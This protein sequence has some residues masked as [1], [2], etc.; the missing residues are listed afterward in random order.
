[1]HDNNTLRAARTPLSLAILS[2]LTMAGNVAQAAE[3][4][5]ET[6]NVLAS[7]IVAETRV[8]S[9]AGV[10]AQI[11]EAQL[12]D[13]NALDLASAL[14]RTPGVQISRFNPVGSFGGG[15]GGAVYIR[16]MG[17]SRPGSE[18]KTY[19]DGV[20]FYMGTW[21]HPLLDLL[22][23]N[24][25]SSVIVHKGPQPQSS[26]NNFASVNLQTR[27]AATDGV[28][29]DMRVTAGSFHT[30]TEQLT[31][32]AKQGRWDALLAQGAANSDG[33]RDNA[34]GQL[35][36][37][38]GRVG[39]Q[40]DEI[41]S[42]GV[43]VL[44]TDNEA[45]D[46]GDERIATRLSVPEY[47]TSASLMSG[48]LAHNQ[49]DWSGEL[50]VYRS[51]GSGDWLQQPANTF[52]DF[53]TSGLIW[54]ERL[55]I[56]EATELL[57]GADSHRVS[58]DVVESAAGVNI[59]TGTFRLDSW[60]VALA[61]DVALNEAWTLTPSIGARGYSHSEFGGSTTPHAGLTL[62]S[63]RVLLYANL[64]QG[65]NYPGLEAPVLAA[66]I[67]PLG[68]SWQ[69][70]E[71]EELDHKEIGGTYALSEASSVSIS[72][73]EDDVSNR[74]VFGFP[75]LVAPPPQFLNLGS[76][77]I[78]GTELA[79]SHQASDALRVFAALTTLDTA[80][81]DLPYTPERALTAGLNAKIGAYTLVLD[82]QYQSEILAMS[83]ARA[84]GAPNTQALKAFTVLNARLS[85]PLSALGAKGE[86]FLAA[87]NLFDREYQFQPGYPMPGTG[88]Q[89]G[90]SASF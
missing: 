26:G 16:G 12:R 21:N 67:R 88:V 69:N 86:I 19:V 3:Q 34:E 18:I 25:M 41:W 52:T 10:S 4:Q 51:A 44:S 83:R 45:Q 7:P 5:I 39:L 29:G 66:Y 81:D 70:L 59:D 76:Y 49:E 62:S 15:E 28:A 80:R 1:M 36:N 38:M 87:E 64:A 75:P 8:D 17:V 6:I 63:E 84:A 47:N 72:V 27:R 50:K 48:V 77:E 14:R 43:T 61:H 71:A 90:I 30:I 2:A 11:S 54:N 24:A 57:F 78:S 58:G 53:E 56:S 73:F 60:F 37:V 35:R 46:P 65:V 20:P 68:N 89:A 74:Y 32:T 55:Q 31:L 85:H 79:F 23:I 82:A 13:Q 40:I 42:A 9:F 22:P 33:H